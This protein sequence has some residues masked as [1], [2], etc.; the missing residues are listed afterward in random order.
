MGMIKWDRGRLSIISLG[1]VVMFI[2]SICLG[3]P[4][5]DQAYEAGTILG[6]CGEPDNAQT[7]TVG[8]SGVLSSIHVKV[9]RNYGYDLVVDVR[10]TIGGVPTE[11]NGDVLA[12][13]TISAS[14][15]PLG[16]PT[17]V[18]FDTA[19]ARINVAVGDVVA[20]VLRVPD[21]AQ[22]ASYFWLC[23]GSDPYPGGQRWG[24]S[25]TWAGGVLGETW[26]GTYA[27][28][29]TTDMDFRTFVDPARSIPA[30]G[31]ILLG[32]LGTGLLAW[33]RRRRTL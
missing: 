21:C 12:A 5:L 26:N 1:L 13:T 28:F 29:A 2:P 6:T 18:E 16:T 20:I 27:A 9:Q 19:S 15:L 24:R 31:A 17:W 25:P 32:T 30:P 8:L 11:A 23:G 33:V 22:P 14:S 7:F 10:N 4:T 3:V